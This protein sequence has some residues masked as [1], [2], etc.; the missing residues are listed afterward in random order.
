MMPGNMTTRRRDVRRNQRGFTL[1]EIITA[2]AIIAVL[3][4]IFIT[5][6]KYVQSHAKEDQTKVAVKT[7]ASMLTEY[8]VQG[9]DM[10]KLDDL[11]TGKDP[12]PNPG[13]V[14]EGAPGR[15]DPAVTLTRKVMNRLLAIPANQKLLAQ[16]PEAKP[17]K[18]GE[19]PTKV[20]S[21]MIWRTADGV[22]FLDAHK[23]PIIYVPRQGL[24]GVTQ[25]GNAITP[26][27]ASPGARDVLQADGVTTRRQG[28][29]FFASAGDDGD[30]SAGDDNKYSFE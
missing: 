9:A 13:K 1:I 14:F 3:I 30:F 22:V 28:T 16:L 4:G 7:L 15:N 19:D 18:P 17:A 26:A 24:V 8:Q 11:Y 6:F 10:K 29:G 2:V 27:L 25:G 20:E 21:E 12:L 23:N 5:G